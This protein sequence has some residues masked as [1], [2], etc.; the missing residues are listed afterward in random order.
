MKRRQGMV[1]WWLPVVALVFG[2]QGEEEAREEAGLVQEE[3]RCR[4]RAAALRWL[5]RWGN[6]G[7]GSEA[8]GW[9]DLMAG[10]CG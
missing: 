1:T 3:G 10:G 5:A 7:R 2:R 8:A 4:I 6:R 9:M